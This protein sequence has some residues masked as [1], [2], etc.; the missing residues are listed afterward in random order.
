M[1]T[2]FT[3][4]V[5]SRRAPIVSYQKQLLVRQYA[6]PIT[7]HEAID[8]LTLKP[9]I[10]E[11]VQNIVNPNTELKDGVYCIRVI[12]DMR[13]LGYQVTLAQ[14]ATAIR[15]AAAA[16]KSF[17]IYEIGEEMQAAGI[18][19]TG[20][21]YAVFF[22]QLVFSLSREKQPEHAYSVFLE[23][24]DREIVPSSD[25]YDAL[26][27]SLASTG[28]LDLVLEIILEAKTRGVSLS[29]PTMLRVLHNAAVQMSAGPFKHC[30]EQLTTVMGVEVPEG[31]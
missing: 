16:K 18:Q 7:N 4:R 22:E 11:M 20:R 29:T 17:V 2:N 5:L 25:T 3:R 6:G 15:V 28:D 27:S 30:W 26:A 31:D 19:D 23:M 1:F 21:N 9:T 24:R 8:A 13:Q 12:R 10:E 14:F